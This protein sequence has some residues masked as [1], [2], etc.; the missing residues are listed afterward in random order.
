M[1]FW[2]KSTTTDQYKSANTDWRRSFTQLG[3]GDELHGKQELE[4][5]ELLQTIDDELMKLDPAYALR[6]VDG[7]PDQTAAVTSL[8]TAMSL[9]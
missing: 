5:P 3:F 4:D 8:V 1:M 7:T 6:R 9:V 2:Y